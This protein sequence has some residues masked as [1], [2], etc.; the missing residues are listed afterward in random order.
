MLAVLTTYFNP[1]GYETKQKNMQ[2][3]LASMERDSITPIIVELAFDDQPYRI[4]EALHVR[5]TSKLWQKER[6]LNI[7][8]DA[9]P[10]SIDKI[11]WVDNDI[12]FR[13]RNWLKQTELALD[14]FD[15]VQPFERAVRLPKE[16]TDLIGGTQV[17]Q[18]L[19]YR[20]VRL[21]K[22][23]FESDQ[24]VKTGT[25]GYAW[26]ARR[27]VLERAGGFYDRAIMDGGDRYMAKAFVGCATDTLFDG[28]GS[29]RQIA[30][31][32]EWAAKIGNCKVG[33]VPGTILHLWHGDLKNRKYTERHQ[34]FRQFNFDP[35]RDIKV[36]HNGVFEWA[37]EK[38][39]LHRAVADYFISRKEDG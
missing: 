5:A 27:E 19:G 35:I 22:E 7:A 14:E 15:V 13:N 8:M 21:G 16:C 32:K 3:F 17:I 2:S 11:A 36:A 39:E 24:E 23:I 30:H 25:V 1:A 9:L 4:P 12:I 10:A 26:A 31:F 37:T 29:W 20:V 34:L 28:R 33:F 38:F 6:L 18:S